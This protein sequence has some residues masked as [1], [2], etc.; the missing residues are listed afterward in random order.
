MD[1]E[2]YFDWM[3]S[4]ALKITAD[5]TNCTLCEPECP[6][7]AIFEGEEYFEIDPDLC[8]ECVG[9]NETP[10]CAAVC[11]VECCLDDEKYPESEESL[12]AKARRIHPGESFEGDL[13]SRYR[14]QEA[15][16]EV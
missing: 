16:L 9:F 11:P 8:T 14:V 3:T 1:L 10:A 15:S 13:P 4:M 5:C 12:I 7:S 6:N 2:L